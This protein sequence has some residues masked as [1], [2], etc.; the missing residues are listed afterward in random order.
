MTRQVTYHDDSRPN[1]CIRTLTR[2]GLNKT[3]NVKIG[4]LMH[5]ILG[6]FGFNRLGSKLVSKFL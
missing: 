4:Q 1:F 2:T 3:G 6:F 5:S